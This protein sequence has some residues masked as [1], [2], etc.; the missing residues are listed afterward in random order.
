MRGIVALALAL[1]LFAAQAAIVG[2][3]LFA[4]HVTAQYR[5]VFIDKI[6]EDWVREPAKLKSGHL[7]W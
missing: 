4:P 7:D 1:A 2:I 3:G 5:A 6:T